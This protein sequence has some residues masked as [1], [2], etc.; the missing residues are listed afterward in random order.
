ML[1]SPRTLSPVAT[2]LADQGYR[3]ILVEVVA[4]WA[5]FVL[6]IVNRA[7]DAVGF[8]LQPKRWIVE[9][10]IAWLN[11]SRR[12]RKE[13][14]HYPESSETM[15]DIA[16]IRLMLRRLTSRANKPVIP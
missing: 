16:S 2:H 8:Q 11:R 5:Q 3:G 10:S 14:E 6:E 15:V 4:P 9:R 1:R 13:Y 7:V 12:L